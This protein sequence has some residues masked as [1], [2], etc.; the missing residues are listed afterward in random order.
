MTDQATFAAALPTSV[1][2]GVRIG[3]SGNFSEDFA[4]TLGRVTERLLKELGKVIDL[5]TLDGVTI[6]GDYEQA[7]RQLDRGFVSSRV[8]APTKDIATGVAMAPMVL[9]DGNLKTH[10]VLDTEVFKPLADQSDPGFEKALY[11]F[12]HEC[13][14]VEVTARFDSAFPGVLLRQ[15]FKSLLDELRWSV[16]LPAWDEYAACRRSYWLGADLTDFYE[17]N[18]LDHLDAEP[19]RRKAAIEDFRKTRDREQLLRSVYEI[20]ADLLK[21][22]SYYLGNLAAAKASW[23]DRSALS[24]KLAG[25]WFLPFFKRLDASL[26]FIN[27]KYGAWTDKSD[28]EALGDIAKDMAQEIGVFAGEVKGGGTHVM[29]SPTLGFTI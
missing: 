16:I 18:L 4:L 23:E 8:L 9:R 3:V 26:E 13:A 20:C 27:H 2:N 14:H 11:A 22:A 24:M 5:R 12:T 15:P 21:F 25:S 7:L 6:A 1:P 28:F 17:Q 29:V 10:I 19:G